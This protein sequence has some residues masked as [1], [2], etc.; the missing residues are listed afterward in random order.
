MESAKLDQLFLKCSKLEP[1]YEGIETVDKLAVFKVKTDAVYVVYTGTSNEMYAH[2]VLI[3]KRGSG[4]V[5]FFDSLGQIPSAIDKRITKFITRLEPSVLE[6]N[7]KKVQAN[8]TCTCGIWVLYVA[9][10]LME[11]VPFVNIIDQ[12]SETN[13]RKNDVFIF[14]WAK[15][16]LPVSKSDL[17]DCKNM[18]KRIVRSER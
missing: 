17:L 5:V 18:P 14:K 4:A 13:L 16:H 11:G 9:Y 2:F 12:F 15:A 10:Y 3:V 7:R 8:D 1:F 6:V